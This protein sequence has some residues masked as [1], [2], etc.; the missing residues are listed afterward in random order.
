VNIIKKIPAAAITILG[1][2]LLLSSFGIAQQTEG[3]LAKRIKVQATAMGQAQKLGTIV[4]ID[5]IINEL[6][7]PED[8]KALLSAFQAK[9]NEGLV[10]ALEKMPSKGRLA[11]S[12]TLGYDVAYIRRF[13]NKDGT[14]T[15]RIVT[16]RAIRF[17]EVWHDTRSRDYSLSALEIVFNRNKKGKIRGKGTLTPACQFDIDDNNQ[18]RLKLFENAWTLDHVMVYL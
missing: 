9:G 14:V 17:G 18:L 1:C 13:D 15:M 4:N 5:V 8:Q 12:G 2:M 10:N 7:T 11:I 3:K 6:S 16:D